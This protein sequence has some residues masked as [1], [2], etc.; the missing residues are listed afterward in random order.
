MYAVLDV[1]V[2]LLH[3]LDQNGQVKIPINVAIL[4]STIYQL[5]RKKEYQGLLK[6]LRWDNSIHG[7]Y[8]PDLS[9]YLF[10]LEMAGLIAEAGGKY[11]ALPKL[12][13]CWEYR[14]CGRFNPYELGLLED[15]ASDLALKLVETT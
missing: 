12:H 5:S 3:F 6:D 2:G 15:L 1:V 4:Y 11:V 9:D 14:H 8:S 13:I 10:Y 7:N